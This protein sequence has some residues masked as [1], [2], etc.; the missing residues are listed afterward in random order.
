MRAGDII[1]EANVRSMRP[2]GGLLPV[3]L[4]DLVGK[5]VSEDLEIGAAVTWDVVEP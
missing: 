5:R 4:K 1:S 2:A 3:H